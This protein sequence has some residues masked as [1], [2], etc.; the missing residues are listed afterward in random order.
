LSINKKGRCLIKYQTLNK[1]YEL[2][3][4]NELLHILLKNRGV[5]DPERLLNISD[6][7]I[8]DGML[9]KNMD[10]GLNMLNWH[11]ENDS[12]I[13]IIDDVDND[14][15]TSATTIDNY[16][17]D[18]NKNIIITHS[19][20]NDKVHGIRVETLLDFNFDLLIVPDAGSED[21]KECKELKE[22]LDIDIL[23]LDHHK[24]KEDNPYAILINCQDGIYPNNTLSGAGV[25]YKFI[26]EYDKKYGYDFA[27]KYLDLVA[28]GI[29][30]DS[31]DLR[32]FETRQL[33]LK[34]LKN[35]QNKFVNEVVKKQQKSEFDEVN[36]DFVGWKISPLLN[37]V[38]RSGTEEEKIELIDAM[39]GKE[40]YKEYQPRRKNKNDPKPEPIMQTLQESMV[41]DATNIK[42]RQDRL[43]KKGMELLIKKI[44]EQHLDK[45]KVIIVDGTED[46]EKTF[47]G[48]VANKLANI[49][50]RPI[51]VL[52]KMSM[53]SKDG[54]T[55]FGGS[56]R[57]Y[58]LSSIVSFF[59]ILEKTKLFYDV[60]GHS[61]AGGYK[62]LEEDI[63][64]A[65]N[66]LN[67]ILKD[68]V[69]EDVYLVDYEIPV[70]RLK[71]KHVLQV[72]QWNN[73]WGNTLNEP[74][75]AVTDIT[76]KV[77]DIKLLGDKK[78]F[79]KFD[80]AI[81]QNKISFIKMFANEDTYNTMIMKNKKGLSK[82]SSSK[83]KMDIIGKFTINHWNDNEYPQVE[84]VDFNV[85]QVKDFVF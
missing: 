24:F 15:V 54:K 45:N 33:V 65:I 67:E 85:S 16:C 28:I 82:Q 8:L 66:K 11:L 22:K 78:N 43:V 2:I 31:M 71:E 62:I 30:G 7:D 84:I 10:R 23:I 17:H 58:K 56:F 12:K 41:R 47:T 51:V 53:K 77:E 37:A 73:I 68:M 36:I 14:G 75:F 70:G 49:Y 61:N 32:N 39:L 38:I 13:H 42:A 76:L 81:G 48:L 60:G 5:N 74:L 25:V 34:G 19:M 4:E 40:G 64:K 69:I 35:I 72:G 21:I 6:N 29:I 26:K 46:I 18:I 44:N 59:D 20:N 83:V 9:L 52:R 55:I 1:N 27:D 80:K 50:K 63:P 3:N 57:N 79:I